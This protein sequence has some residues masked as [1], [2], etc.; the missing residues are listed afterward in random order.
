MKKFFPFLNTKT[1][2]KILRVFWLI[3]VSFV[4]LY[5]CLFIFARYVETILTFPG[6]YIDTLEYNEAV[7]IVES[8]DIRDIFLEY[9]GEKVHGIYI[10]NDAKYTVYYFH[11]NWGDLT[12]FYADIERIKSMGYNILALEYPGYGRAGSFPLVEDIMEHADILFEYA[13]KEFEILETETY[14]YGYSIGTG[15]ALEYAKNRNFPKIVLEAPYLSRYDLSRG[16]YGFALQKLFF[17]PNSLKN[18]ENITKSSAEV[19]ILHGAQD[20]LIP[21]EQG[22]KLAEI[23]RIWDTYFLDI[24]HKDHFWLLQDGLVYEK[25]QNFLNFGESSIKAPFY[26][27]INKSDLEKFILWSQLKKLDVMTD[28]SI[29]KYVDPS[30]SFSDVRYIPVDMRSLNLTHIIDTKGNAKVRAQA[31]SE[32]EALAQSYFDEK[33][34]KIVVVSTY[35]SYDYQAGIKARGCPD[36]LCAKAGHSEHQ[37][38]LAID[39]WSAS[40]LQQWEQDPKLQERYK[41]FADNAHRFGFHQSYQ[42]GLKI[43]GYHKEPW[44]WRYLWIELASYLKRENIT[45]AQW[46]KNL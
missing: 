1:K 46:Y 17:L 14:L 29:T 5:L 31:A 6:V 2:H 3:S 32:F 22:K 37:W 12:Y 26:E 36:S 8:L 39:I 45:F 25:V 33:G 15:V 16:H 11:G 38:G 30:V 35:R 19:F 13:K 40:S 23:A 28:T 21:Q 34:E 4:I 18:F 44:H 41:W 20:Q 10:D 24:P 43:D 27:I 9:K 7:H 42:N